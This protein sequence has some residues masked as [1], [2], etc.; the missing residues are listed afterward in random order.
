MMRL[1]KME[2]LQ[3]MLQQQEAH[4]AVA[5][6]IIVQRRA[7]GRS[8]HAA[9]LVG[10]AVAQTPSSRLHTM[11]SNCFAVM[12]E[13]GVVVPPTVD[14]HRDA[15]ETIARHLAQMHTSLLAT[16]STVTGSP[17]EL[18]GRSV[19]PATPRDFPTSEAAALAAE[20]EFAANPRPDRAV[21]VPPPE[22]GGNFKFPPPSHSDGETIFTY[23]P[24]SVKTA[25]GSSA[26]ECGWPLCEEFR[27]KPTVQRATVIAHTR[28]VHTHETLACPQREKCKSAIRTGKV[29]TTYS[30]QCFRQHYAACIES[31]SKKPGDDKDEGATEEAEKV[32]EGEK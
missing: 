8:L 17:E 24:R 4:M 27:R 5:R 20:Q 23:L 26:Y 31:V 10:A 25:G 14:S 21:E 3:G 32:H 9:Q 11:V 2:E 22:K 16:S 13:A 18:E 12:R 7:I 1:S 6:G 15:R 19:I 28:R 29:Y 30:D